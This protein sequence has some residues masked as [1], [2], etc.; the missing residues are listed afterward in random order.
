MRILAILISV[1]TLLYLVLSLNVS[2]DE[3]TNG[4]KK[5]ATSIALLPSSL[6]SN[7]LPSEVE[8][9]TK[10]L[11]KKEL[12]QKEIET[13]QKPNRLKNA[14]KIGDVEYRFVGI[15]SKQDTEFVLMQNSEQ[16]L[17]KFS[18]GEYVNKHYV[19][20][21]IKSD[22]IIFKSKDDAVEHK[23]FKRK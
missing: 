18:V 14:L 15:L 6:S 8:W 23:L 22:R 13:S 9:E 2:V 20:S 11:N 16:E 4:I 1:V 10:L 3:P 5:A 12:A 7:K 21:E 17:K 19:L